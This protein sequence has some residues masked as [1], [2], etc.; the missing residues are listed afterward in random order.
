MSDDQMSDDPAWLE[1]TRQLPLTFAQVREDAWID[2]E[3]AASCGARDILMIA[4]GGCTAAY[5]AAVSQPRRLTLVD[6]NAAQLGLARWKLK[7][8]AE[9]DPA[10]RLGLLG[11]SPLPTAARQA[12]LASDLSDWGLSSDLFGPLSLVAERGPDRLGR[13][14]VLF[15]RLKDELLDVAD[16]LRTLLSLS[17]P[18]EQ[19]ERAR[20]G[21]RLGDRLDAALDRVMSLDTLV[22]LFGPLATANRVQPF[23]RHFAERIRVALAT[24]PAANNP[25]LWQMLQGEFPDAAVHPWFAAPTPAQLPACEFIHAPM[26]RALE[27]LNG[28]QF[29]LVHL[30]NILDWLEPDDASRALAAAGQ[31][32][33]PGGR[34]IVRQLN[35]QLAVRELPTRF[36][37]LA[38]DSAR[39]HAADRSFFYRDL[40]VGRRR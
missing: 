8:L 15:E 20:S 2:A 18:L 10:T 32:L 36:E 4:S 11:H 34:V 33:R 16:E 9:C 23:A 13:Y 25:Y 1:A 17:D 40:H 28:E 38:E 35:S 24:L 5:L 26:E 22:A 6:V 12:K 27:S 21:T 19:R 39:W 7:L 3:L 31:V 37:W 14:E 30:S 29:D